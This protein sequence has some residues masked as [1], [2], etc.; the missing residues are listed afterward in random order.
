MQPGA[1]AAEAVAVPTFGAP[2]LQQRGRK[3]GTARRTLLRRGIIVPF[4]VPSP[5]EVLAPVH[6]FAD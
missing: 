4:N 3:R 1:R 5:A 6:K 2:I